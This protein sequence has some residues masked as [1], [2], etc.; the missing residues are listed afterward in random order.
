M[1]R[2]HFRNWSSVS[3]LFVWPASYDPPHIS[4]IC[5]LVGDRMALHCVLM[6]CVTSCHLAP[7]L[8]DRINV[9]YLPRTVWVWCCLYTSRKA[10][11]L[12]R[13]L[14]YSKCIFNHTVRHCCF[15]WLSFLLVTF[16]FLSGSPSRV[17]VFKW[18][19]YLRIRPRRH[20]GKDR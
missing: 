5:K 20:L 12:D 10:T 1:E 19:L 13:S 9:R 16:L 7:C 18:R 2:K 4:C 11:I 8:D 3:S 15:A 6:A 17:D 14:F